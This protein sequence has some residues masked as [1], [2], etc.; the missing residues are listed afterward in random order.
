MIIFNF[1]EFLM[2]RLKKLQLFKIVKYLRIWGPKI[3]AF[4]VTF[5]KTKWVSA[6]ITLEPKNQ[7]MDT[8]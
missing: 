3:S 2:L 4:V 7:K 8:D 6:G 1:K 5:S